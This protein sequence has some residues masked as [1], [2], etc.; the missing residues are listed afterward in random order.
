MS[1]SEVGSRGI[2]VFTAT[3]N[4]DDDPFDDHRLFLEIDAYRFEIGILGQQPHDRAFLP[5]ALDRHLVLEARDD[6]LAIAHLGRAMHG[7][8]I[9]VQDAGVLHAHAAH[10][11]QVM[12]LGLE[13][14]RIDLIA[15]LD[16]LLGEDRA[17]RG[18]AA[19]QR[20]AQLFAQDVLQLD[21]ARGAGNQI[22]DA[23]ALQARADV[24]RRHSAT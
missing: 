10:F 14:L 13:Q 3:Q 21:A 23:L 16:V 1:A 7:D 15:R 2:H 18:D 24:P 22:D 4:P 12:R 8:Q 9:A 19:D 11:Q 20:Q 5:V 17:A 6:D